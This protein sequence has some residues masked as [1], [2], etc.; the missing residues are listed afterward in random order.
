MKII[1]RDGCT[2]W[3]SATLREPF[4]WDVARRHYDCS[5]A[6]LLPR[7]AGRK[8][9]LARGLSSLLTTG[10]GLLWVTEWSVYPSS[11]NMPLFLGYR[12]SLGEER[13]LHSAP[14]HLFEDGDFQVVE[15]LIA[16]GLYF[17]WDLHV[18]DGDSLWLHISHDEVIA[19]H[20]SDQQVLASADELL[21]LYSLDRL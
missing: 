21:S 11:E 6:Y 17:C 12:R 13:T 5:V 15:C 18:F 7:E 14:G 19:A 8:T 16:L 1:D 20:A 4:D 10:A 3:L 9:A 2:S